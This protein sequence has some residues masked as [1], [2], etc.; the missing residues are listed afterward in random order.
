[1]RRT[2]ISRS[3]VAT[4]LMATALAVSTAARAQDTVQVGA[5]TQRPQVHVV[6]PGETL[7]SLA[8]LYLGDPLLWPEIYRLN[9]QVIEDPHWIFPGEELL[10]A[11]LAAPPQAP[12]AAAGDT[13]AV[14]AAAPVQADTVRPVAAVAPAA[15]VQDTA[16]AV[17]QPPRPVEAPPVEAPKVEAPPPPPPPPPADPSAPTIFSAQRRQAGAASVASAISAVAQYRP[18]RRGEFYAAG[19]LTEGVNLPWGR[20]LGEASETPSERSYQT[21]SAMIYQTVELRAPSGATYREGDSLLVAELGREV[22]GGWGRV[23]K[24]TGIVR[25]TYARGEEVLGQVIVQFHRVVDGQ[26]TLPL[27]AFRDPGMVAPV[28]VVN[29]LQG[30]VIGLRDE[31]PVPIQQNI[32][33]LDVGAAQGVSLGDVFEVLEPLS[34]AHAQVQQPVAILQIVHVRDRSASGLIVQISE[35]G[36]H[37]GQ[38]VRLIR[39]MPS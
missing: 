38:P 22:P 36:I 15:P 5:Q 13:A 8:R 33:F 23:V 21:S 14:G 27:E 6:Q 9:T 16:Q 4:L 34:A 19:F 11:G 30:S 31:H 17:M 3:R 39:K 12:Q 26:V 37:S 24:P 1:M 10:L 18:V 2:T 25:V 35:P 32:V 28:P 7:W 29:G 20:V